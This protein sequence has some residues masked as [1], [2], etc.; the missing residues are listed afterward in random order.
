MTAHS[1]GSVCFRPAPAQAV[2]D[3]ERLNA[4]P[5]RLF[6]HLSAFNDSLP[7]L[8]NAR[9]VFVPT[10]WGVFAQ[11]EAERD[12]KASEEIF[13]YYGDAHGRPW[14]KEEELAAGLAAMR[15]RPP[16]PVA[17]PGQREQ[18]MAEFVR[19]YLSSPTAAAAHRL[20]SQL[21][22]NSRAGAVLTDPALAAAAK[23]P[24]DDAAAD[25]AGMPSEIR[26]VAGIGAPVAEQ[27]LLARLCTEALMKT[28][29]RW[30]GI[31]RSS[32]SGGSV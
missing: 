29:G 30:Q 1:H 5:R 18:F 12:I 2:K 6:L 26:A 24:V 7:G 14:L 9:F 3:K 23:V 13:V 17:P 10:P 28:Q 15:D 11:V 21:V 16:P 22:L 8:P 19:S 31:A 27:E 32:S 20:A 25:R 4:V